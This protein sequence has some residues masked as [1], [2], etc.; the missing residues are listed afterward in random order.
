M[1][2]YKNRESFAQKDA[3]RMTLPGGVIKNLTLYLEPNY[4]YFNIIVYK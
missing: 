4:V 1:R 3:L 2:L